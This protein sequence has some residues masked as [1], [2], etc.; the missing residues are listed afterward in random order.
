MKLPSFEG[1]S[2]AGS[3]PL[4][5]ITPFLQRGALALR[6][7]T[8]IPTLL[9]A[10]ALLLTTSGRAAIA[11]ALRE[12]KITTG[13]EVLIPAY[14]CVAL[15]APIEASD[16][17]AVSY[18]VKPD[19]SVDID[20]L[21]RRITRRTR[22][23]VV[24]HFF[25]FPQA[26]ETIREICD[27]GGL[28]L[29]E[30]C[31]HAFYSPRQSPPVGCYGDYSIGSLMKFFP[32]FDG[33]CLASYRRPPL[34][35]RLLRANGALYQ[36][37]ALFHILEH[38]ARWSRSRTLRLL[39]SNISRIGNLLKRARPKLAR[40]VANSSPAAVYGSV[41]FE[42]QWVYTQPAIVSRLIARHANHARSIQRRRA[43]YQ[44]LAAGLASVP[45]GTPF[46][47]DLPDGVAPYVFPFLLAEPDVMY[48]ALRA[49][50]V[51][52]YRW[53]A[54]NDTDCTV[55]SSLKFRLVQFPCHQDLMEQDIQAL[56]DIVRR[57][58][59]H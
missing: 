7:R 36:L 25:G 43:C 5:P 59:S 21:K 57:V 49:A 39:I 37:R 28:T 29:I 45:G 2:T 22:C 14:H 20:D 47:T 1:D 32:V 26:V 12:L 10:P 17:V 6:D 4:F 23:V 46:R 54:A 8:G 44:M 41:E 19:L 35:Q 50:G 38:S 18:R 16:A 24:V 3:G 15:S 34:D 27:R 9:D 52:M 42:E 40:D 53:D 51:P 33:G 56:I 48:P 31:A 13:D 58:L 11:L 30:D 55:T